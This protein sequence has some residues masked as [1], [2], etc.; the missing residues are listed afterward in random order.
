MIKS[1]IQGHFT[2]QGDPGFTSSI[3]ALASFL[4]PRHK[5]LRFVTNA[6][7]KEALHSYV[8]SLIEGYQAPVKEKCDEPPVKK[9]KAS[10]I[11]CL[12]GD[13]AEVNEGNGLDAEIDRYIA[14][15]V[16]IRDPLMWWKHYQYRFPSLAM[17]ARKFL[18]VMGTS[19]PSERVFSVA[20][21]TITKTRAKLDANVVDEIII[22]QEPEASTSTCERQGLDEEDDDYDDDY[23]TLPTLY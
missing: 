10:V 18:C 20:G 2:L 8:M 23:P 4:D 15:P 22:K 1:G 17:L 6:A 11:S 14:E 16:Q 3:P 9:L 5:S 13:F 21:L 12:D 7:E 19:V